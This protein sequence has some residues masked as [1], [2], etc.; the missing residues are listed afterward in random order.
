MRKLCCA[1]SSSVRAG[2]RIL[3]LLQ[4]LQARHGR[5]LG[6]Q[7]RA[8]AAPILGPQSLVRPSAPV[9]QG[10][11]TGLVPAAELATCRPP[12]GAARRLPL[13]ACTRWPAVSCPRAAWRAPAAYPPCCSPPCCW[14]RQWWRRPGRATGARSSA[15]SAWLG[16]GRFALAEMDLPCLSLGWEQ[17]VSPQAALGRAALQKTLVL[18]CVPPADAPRAARTAAASSLTARTPMVRAAGGGG[19]RLSTDR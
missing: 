19:A 14:R 18:R 8:R 1:L 16:V 9:G 7:T 6:T 5:L 4:H 10:G 15:T 13:S 17:M 2:V 3:C 12:P 11:E